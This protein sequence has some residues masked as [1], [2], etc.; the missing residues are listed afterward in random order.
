V[1]SQQ[2]P[3]VDGLACSFLLSTSDQLDYGRLY[4]ACVSLFLA[5]TG[6]D[7]VK[8]KLTILVGTSLYGKIDTVWNFFI[9]LLTFK[10]QSEDIFHT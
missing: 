1:N 9:F 10:C 7:K 3:K 2:T 6:A 8:D 4:N 5:G